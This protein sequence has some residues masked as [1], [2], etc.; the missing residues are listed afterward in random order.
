MD[1]E[2]IAVPPEE[3]TQRLAQLHEQGYAGLNLTVPHKHLAYDLALSEQWPLST[4]ASQAG[5]VNTL[6]RTDQGWQ[7]DNTDGL[8]LLTDLLR[9]LEQSD[10]SGL[11]LLM[12]GAAER[13]RRAGPIGGSRSGGGYG[14]EPNT[15]EGPGPGGSLFC[16]LSNCLMAGRRAAESGAWCQSLR[17]GL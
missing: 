13:P 1:Y 16:R 9:S 8:G 6:I 3:L 2:A 17:P 14:G 7:A 10:L 12:I 11:R 4:L 5:A 15:R